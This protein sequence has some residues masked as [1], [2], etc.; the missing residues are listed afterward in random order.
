VVALKIK[1]PPVLVGA[2]PLFYVQSLTL[3]EGYEFKQIEDS[4]FAQG[5][6]PTKKTIGIEAILPGPDRLLLKKALE[7]MA[8]T[9]RLFLAAAAPLLAVTGL[10]VVSG[11]TISTDM[12]ITSLAFTQS[13][14]RRDA[15]H[16]KL[17]LLHVPRNSAAA[18][19]GELADVA[20]AA[21]T[22]VAGRV[23]P[24]PALAPTFP[25]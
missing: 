3:E 23:S 12:Q 11:M 7:A 24:G 10:P 19:I 13:T 4:G 8:L 16:L 20:L 21:G 6:A 15:L 18:L 5:I 14:E 17:N 9:S 2:V 1:N 25:L 22:A